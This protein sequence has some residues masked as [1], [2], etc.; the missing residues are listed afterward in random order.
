MFQ[1]VYMQFKIYD[2]LFL[3]L[4][5]TSSYTHLLSIFCVQITM[6]DFVTENKYKLRE[7]T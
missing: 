1:N 3:L 7:V 4:L 5:Y 2:F 6:C